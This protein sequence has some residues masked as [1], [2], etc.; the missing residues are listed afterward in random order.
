M[1]PV[2]LSP[3]LER[4]RIAVA[5]TIPCDKQADRDALL[6]QP[7]TTLVINYLTWRARLIR[8]RQRSV[9]IWPEVIASPHYSVYAAAIT[10]IATEFE[11][12][13][14]INPRLS[15]QTRWKGFK[16]QTTPPT[17]LT[18]DERMR[19]GWRGKDRARVLYD[20]HHLHMGSRSLGVAGR[21][22][23]LLFVGVLPERALFLTIGDH[24]SFDDGTI[25]RLMDSYA[26]NT[27][28]QEGF[29][30][31]GPGVTTA[32]TQISDTFKAIKIVN[33]LEQLDLQ[34]SAN[35]VTDEQGDFALDYDDIVIKNE[36][37]AETHRFKG[38]L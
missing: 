21:T 9:T 36:T 19:W 35:D 31:A 15:N 12:G 7:I 2:P 24:A 25:S 23:E 34:L 32:G 37:G 13:L 22:G 10:E 30:I 18:S 5:N 28:L 6:D 3:R 26:E 38:R 11:D 17:N 27:S 29:Y 8:V 20:V 14:D 1:A 16:A 33:E 4:L